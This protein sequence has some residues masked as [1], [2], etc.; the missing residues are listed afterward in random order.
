MLRPVV[1]TPQFQCCPVCGS[2][3]V[4]SLLELPQLPVLSTVLWPSS[5][6]A[7]ATVRGD[8][9]LIFCR[10]C[11]HLYNGA[12]D[13]R[14]IEYTVKYE[15]SLHYSGVF[16]EYI[17][18]LVESLVRRYT[19]K[20]KTVL[21]VG[22]GQGDFLELLCG[23]AQCTGVGFDPAYAGGPASA[24]EKRMSV[25]RDLYSSKYS[26]IQA[27]LIVCRQTLE[28]IAEPQHMLSE[29]RRAIGKRTDTAV[30]F[31]VP[32]ALDLLR[33][34]DLWDLMIYEHFSH[35]SPASLA[36]A[37]AGAGFEAQALQELFGGLFLGIHAKPAS[38][39]VHLPADA[40][41]ARLRDVSRLVDGFREAIP[42]MI[43]RWEERFEEYA[44]RRERIV[45]WGA[46][47]RCTAFL[48]LVRKSSLIEYV[49]DINPRKHGTYVS[50]SGQKIIAP[51]SLPGYDPGV[52]VLLNPLYELEVSA[53]LSELRVSAT[54]VG[55]QGDILRSVTPARNNALLNR[56]LGSPKR[57]V[58]IA[59]KPEAI[60][61]LGDGL[62]DGNL[63][64]VEA[65]TF[66]EAVRVAETMSPDMYLV[67]H[68]FD[69][70]RPQR[71]IKF[72]KSK[73][74]A[75]S[76]PIVVVRVLP[77]REPANDEEIRRSYITLGAD[78]Y[79]ILLDHVQ[80]GGSGAAVKQFKSV[81]KNRL[82]SAVRRK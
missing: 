11:G 8:I 27:D 40:Q 51:G 42:K 44:D 56:R 19:P 73:P 32:N 20:G 68:H 35:Y 50:G 38:A 43:R 76:T 59:D 53:S 2:R 15:N 10:S 3:D 80:R 75:A 47:S 1:L 17:S 24:G 23:R 71:L 81:V 57:V 26:D 78:D 48:N 37:F 39:A 41:S 58:L 30:F 29:V 33:S 64:F 21:E 12:F 66:D 55:P 67:G 69:D 65:N 77:L 34:H 9:Q 4:Q 82:G 45:V 6:E 18:N 7:R 5:E 13:A 61:T 25:V 63:N 70:M 54:I 62:A 72:L 49:V 60:S 16:Q 28:H 46:G 14:L 36:A 79:V 22:C 74:W 52:V 31:E